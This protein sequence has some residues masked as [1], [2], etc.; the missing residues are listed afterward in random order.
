MAD[1]PNKDEKP[2]ET[3]EELWERALRAGK[4]V[5]RLLAEENVDRLY[6]MDMLCIWQWN[7]VYSEIKEANSTRQLS[8]LVDMMKYVDKYASSRENRLKEDL[9]VV[10]EEDEL[11]NLEQYLTA[12]YLGAMRNSSD[13]LT[14]VPA[15]LFSDYVMNRVRSLLHKRDKSRDQRIAL[16][17]R[18]DGMEQAKSRVLRRTEIPKDAKNPTRDYV[19][20]LG[21]QIAQFIDDDIAT[22][23]QSQKEE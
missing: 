9:K 14:N 8:Q 23:K 13:G 5:D 3:R 18:I 1:T 16:E 12:A 6:M 17:A 20:I 7:R 15:T 21:E 2:Q 4:G 11:E 22:L 10:G 19:V